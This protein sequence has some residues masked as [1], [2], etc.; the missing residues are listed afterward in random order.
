CRILI[1]SNRRVV[2]G[3]VYLTNG[4]GCAKE[5]EIGS[6]Y[7]NPFE[8]VAATAWYFNPVMWAYY[9]AP[10]ITSGTT[11][12]TFS[13]KANCTRAQIVTFLWHAMGDPE[14]KTT[15]NP[16]TDVKEGKYYFKPVLWA[17]ENGIT[18]GIGNGLFGINDPCKREQ[19]VTFIWKTFNAP[20]PIT[21]ENPF[22]DVKEG[23][24]YYNA[25][26]WAVE[27]GITSGMGGGL[28]GVGQTCTRGQIVT[29]LSAAF[30][31]K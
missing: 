21:T 23:K 17:V 1:P 3:T 11:A 6:G 8:D 14:P 26:L 15:E 30:N 13:P 27:N 28:F 7:D 12:T 20:E 10:Q 2:D 24:Y 29:F 31:I 18:S 4:S 22:T 25:V 19:V 9:H 5:V 16:F